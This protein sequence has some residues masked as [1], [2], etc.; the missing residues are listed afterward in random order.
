MYETYKKYSQF[1]TKEEAKRLTSAEFTDVYGELNKEMGGKL[2]PMSIIEDQTGLVQ[3]LDKAV[4][5]AL[6]RTKDGV[7][8][9]KRALTS[10]LGG[11]Q[12]QNKQDSME[13]LQKQ[14]EDA[15]SGL[16]VEAPDS[17]AVS[18]VESLMVKMG[19]EFGARGGELAAQFTNQLDKFKIDSAL[20]A[21]DRQMESLTVKRDLGRELSDIK[22]ETGL[23][24]SSVLSDRIVTHTEYLT[25]LEE[26]KNKYLLLGNDGTKK[27]ADIDI[28]I[29]QG[30]Y[31]RLKM[32]IT[33]TAKMQAQLYT[34][35][36][37]ARCYNT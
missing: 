24:L 5:G 22:S 33:E 9:I 12:L 36:G 1:V 3:L 10:E 26:L 16:M 37:K 34:T 15:L 6:I 31:D 27:A 18:L 2:G 11:Q 28:Q 21:L 17:A 23:D 25:Q 4:T 19:S 8:V 20:A 14:I 29:E 32:Y 13:S 35:S 7:K 30:K